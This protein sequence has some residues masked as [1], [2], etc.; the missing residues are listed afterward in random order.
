MAL[1]Q[2]DFLL[3]DEE[4]HEINHYFSAMAESHA[5]A[6]EDAQQSVSVNFDF[7]PAFGRTVTARFNA[8][9]NGRLIS[10]ESEVQIAK[11][12]NGDAQRGAVEASHQQQLANHGFLI[13]DD[14]QGSPE[15]DELAKTFADLIKSTQE[16]K[17][18]KG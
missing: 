4:L 10:D 8:E 17:S 6:G 13:S 5:E 18:D 7:M 3:T 14:I 15:A 9:L 11:T 1:T 16:G 2:N 12:T